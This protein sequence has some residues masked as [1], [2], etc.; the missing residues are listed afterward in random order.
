MHPTGRGIGQYNG[1]STEQGQIEWWQ[2][3]RWV[4]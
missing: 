1:Q 4:V 2:A 3:L